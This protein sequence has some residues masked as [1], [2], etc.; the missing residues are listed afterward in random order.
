MNINFDNYEY[1]GAWFGNEK[2]VFNGQPFD[3][4]IQ[5]DGYDDIVIPES[6]KIALSDF[7]DKLNDYTAK[8]EKAVFEYYCT[9]RIEL[10]YDREFNDDF[11]ALS[12]SEEVLEMITLIGI[13][14]P[15][16]DDY[17]EAA[18]SLVFDCTW[19][20]E[21]GLGICFIGEEIDEVGFQDIAL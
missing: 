2:V 8:I 7:L 9:L 12:Q 5:I 11:P 4:E 21:H 6:S 14:V 20:E 19:E 3:V 10:G 13:T 1:D 17:D 18:V 15:D 16:Q